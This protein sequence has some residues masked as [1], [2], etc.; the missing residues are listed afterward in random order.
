MRKHY[1]FL[2]ALCVLA[3]TS[4]TQ[5]SVSFVGNLEDNP[6][7]SEI[8]SWSRSSVTK[9]FDIDLNNLYGSDGYVIMNTANTGGVAQS[10]L[11]SI[12][13]SSPSYT[14][15]IAYS[16]AGAGV[17]GSY[18]GAANILNPTDTGVLN[19]GYSGF[20]GAAGVV[21]PLQELFSYTLNRDLAAGKPYALV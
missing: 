4:V 11:H 14:G 1:M 12:V 9:S 10:V 19:T 6:N 20:G 5:A 2:V 18:N 7:T 15:N 13:E 21:I 17:S 3:S 8:S 16:G